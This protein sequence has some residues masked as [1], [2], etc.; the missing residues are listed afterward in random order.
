MNRP[1]AILIA[2]LLLAPAAARPEALNL[3]AGHL[4]GPG[5]LPDQAT[6]TGL[7]SHLQRGE[8]FM[9]FQIAP[10]NNDGEEP[11]LPGEAYQ[12]KAVDGRMSDG[13]I[14]NEHADVGYVGL[15][16]GQLKLLLAAVYGGPNQGR[17]DFFLDENWN[18]T[19]HDDIAIDPGFGVGVIHIDD[20]RWS[21][22]PRVLPLSTQTARG[23]PAG[24]DRGG[25]KSSGQYIP[26]KVGDDDFDGF[27]DGVFNAVGSFPLDST[28][29]PGAP[30]SQTRTF[31]SDV[32]VTALEAA[33]LTLANGRSHLL[34]A[35]QLEAARTWAAD[36]PEW[37]A[38]ARERLEMARRHL[39]RAIESGG[40]AA[41]LQAA[42]VAAGEIAEELGRGA[43]A[44]S[45]EQHLRRLAEAIETLLSI[46]REGKS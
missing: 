40:P 39:R 41:P 19:I 7:L 29:L 25:T 20:F 14:M 42:D 26:G 5:P 33:I 15:M 3:V 43:G 1:V 32:R 9:E 13:T 17:V 46:R 12:G 4:Y 28:F 30:F 34:A 35:A 2:A 45:R 6:P 24:V 18:W 21:T 27:A 22:G 11:N 37:R 16:Q 44:D 38:G 31:V 36:A 10:F 8:G 23:Y